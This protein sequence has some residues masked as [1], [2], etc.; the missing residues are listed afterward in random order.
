MAKFLIVDDSPIERLTL[1]KCLEK[2][3]HEVIGEAKDGSEALDL[4]KTLMPD[5]VILDII[6]P[7]DNG[8]NILRQILNYD[9]NAKVIMC[10]SSATQTLVITAAQIG[11]KY[12]LVKPVDME[13]LSRIVQNL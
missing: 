2:L 6:M 12:F 4:Y 1:K 11:A 7:N 8:I 10:T 9:K 13:S 5:V 3:N